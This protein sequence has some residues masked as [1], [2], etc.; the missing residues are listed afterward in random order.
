MKTNLNHIKNTGFITPD[1]YFDAVEDNIINTIKQ[2]NSLNLSKETGF[3]TPNNYFNTIEEAIIN[4]IETK[5]TPKVIPLFSKKNLLYALSVSAAVLLLFNLSIFDKEVSFDSLDLQT[6]ENYIIDEGIDYYELAA[7]L[8]ENDFLGVDFLQENITDEA[9][10][11]Y[12]LNNIDI[13]EI[14]IE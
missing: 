5:N 11:N 7:L 2:E 4:K 8:S 10:E 12:L 9:L 6:V 14:I 13:E 1:N 3:K